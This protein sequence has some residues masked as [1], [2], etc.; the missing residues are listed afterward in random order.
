[1]TKHE[2]HSLK[3][4]MQAKQRSLDERV[5][6]LNEKCEDLQRELLEREKLEAD[7]HNQL[8][9]VT[10]EKEKL[11]TQFTQHELCLE[12]HREK[13]TLEL[14]VG[15][16]KHSVAE[17]KEHIRSLREREK[18]LV[19]FPDLT[20]LAH[21][22]PQSN[23]VLDMKQQLQANSIRIEVL[24][25]ENVTLQ[26]SLFKLKERARQNWFH[27]LHL[28][29]G[30]TGRAAVQHRWDTVTEER[31]QVEEK[32][33]KNQTAGHRIECPAPPRPCKFT[34]SHSTSTQSPLLFEN[35][36]TSAVFFCTL[37][38]EA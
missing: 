34:S 27:C 28:V 7:F 10:H 9:Q 16:L 30:S 24:D 25:Q 26:Q 37:T 2:E 17:L 3:S 13:R 12:A 5:D 15:E 29:P 14:Q 23:V 19:A 8:H 33:V 4:S 21:A 31:K 38:V 36:P 32:V 35:M 11:Q 1:V 20:P 18:L 6:T 22:Q